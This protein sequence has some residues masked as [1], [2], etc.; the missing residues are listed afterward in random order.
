MN[1]ED[2]VAETLA[3]LNRSA[4]M[5]T[6]SASLDTSDSSASVM[7][8]LGGYSSSSLPSMREETETRGSAEDSSSLSE[9]ERMR[10]FFPLQLHNV[11]SDDATNDIIRWLPSGKAFIIADKKRFAKELLPDFF[12][13]S[14]FTSFT[15]KLTRWHFNRVPRGALIGAYYHEFFVRDQVELC[16]HMSCRNKSAFKATKELDGRLSPVSSSTHSLKN[17]PSIPSLATKARAVS[18]DPAIPKPLAQE[19]AH[20]GFQAPL[21]TH[22]S[23]NSQTDILR[24]LQ[25]QNSL[26]LLDQARNP[27]N[28]SGNSS[29]ASQ[30]LHLEMCR[31]LQMEQELSNAIKQAN[32]LSLARNL[33]AGSLTQNEN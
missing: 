26:Q 11:I 6:S 17:T 15:R 22:L 9:Q 27:F 10:T 29:L 12:Q 25:L 32:I 3:T 20:A 31:R 33:S 14:Q 30:L 4:R 13:G 5:T 19:R 2:T 23:Q 7:S 24:L 21:S 1:I 18:E 16:Y 28:S 8:N